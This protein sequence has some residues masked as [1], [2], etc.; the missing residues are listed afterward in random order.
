MA[1]ALDVMALRAFDSTT[2]A[3]VEAFMEACPTSVAQQTLAWRN[4]ITSIDRDEPFFLGCRQ[5]GEL[6]GV[7]PAYRFDGPLGAILTSVP[8]VGPLGGVACHAAAD[9]ERVYEALLRAYVDLGVSTG[10]ALVTVISS[11]FWPDRERYER[12]LRPDYV[13]DN[14]CQVLDL[15]EGFTAE[16]SFVGGSQNLRR[17]LR[18]AQAGALWVDEE[19]SLANVEEWYEIHAARHGEIGAT[20]LPKGL[21]TAALEHMI[22]REKARFFF[23][24]RVDT[25]EMIAGGFYLHHGAVI[26]AL[27]PSVRSEHAKHGPAYL[28]ALHSMRWA[29]ARGLRFYNWQGSPPDGG[30]HRF[31]QQWGSRELGYA[32]LTRITGDV[33]PFLESTVPELMS[34]YR[35]HYVLPFDRVGETAGAGVSS[36]RAAWAALEAA[37]R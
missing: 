16:G 21:F 11:P 17:N 33:R 6:V 37:K 2:D 34:A 32:F 35:W 12:H 10:C 23:V 36:R 20:A 30:V 1:M 26:D 27:M 5:A 13:L 24:R 14:A 9:A 19:Q 31:K 7:L 15:A 28:L 22:P 29:R 8:H 18:K 3:E 25:G 4:V